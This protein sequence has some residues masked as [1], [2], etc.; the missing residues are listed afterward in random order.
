MIKLTGLAAELFGEIKK[1]PVVDCHEHLPTE[2]E[3]VAEKVD[4]STLFKHYTRADIEGAGLALNDTEW[5]KH[6]LYDTSKPIMPR[7]ELFKPYFEAVRHGSY[8]FPALCYIRDVLGFEDLNDSTV[9]AVSAKLQEGNTPGL[10]ERVMREL[11]GIETAIQCKECVIEGDQPFFVYLCRDR[12]NMHDDK[13]PD[14]TSGIRRLEAET[15]RNIHALADYVDALGA[16]VADQKKR[17]AV[18]LKIGMAYRRSLVIDDVSAGDADRVFVKLRANVTTGVSAAEQKALEDYLLRR[19]V[20]ACIDS[21]LP[22]VIHTGYQAG[23]RNDIRNARATHLWPLLASYPEARFD[24]FHGSFPYVDDMT[25]LGKYFPNVTLNMCWMHIMGPAVSRRALDEW[26]DAVPVNKIFAFGGDYV[27]V[28]EV[29]GH[30]ELA[31]ADAAAVLAGKIERGR[32]VEKD[33]VDVARLLFNE[34]P[35][36]WYKLT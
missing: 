9:E 20:E 13:C 34:N 35:K 28:E 7:W 17:G 29:Y 27:V 5:E 30:L 33:A 1:I 36:R 23:I 16:Y 21:D 12:V 14:F 6:E 15:G 8:A 18:G 24:L 19:E 3:R 2:A 26:L 31:R 4:F 22:V 10:Y 25:V 11:S 32:M